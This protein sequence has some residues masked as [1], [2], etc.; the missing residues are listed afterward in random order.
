MNEK[1]LNRNN[2]PEQ[3][4]EIFT[5]NDK[6]SVDMCTKTVQPDTIFNYHIQLLY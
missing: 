2:L 4:T 3:S 6:L 1:T 5:L